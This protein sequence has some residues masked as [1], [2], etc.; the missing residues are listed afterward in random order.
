MTTTFKNIRRSPYQAIAAI[1][2]TGSTVFVVAVFI[3]V[4]AASHLLL[5]NFETKPQIIAYLKDSHTQEQVNALTAKLSSTPYVKQ[6]NYVSKDQALEFY[7]KS[8]ANDPLLLGSITDLGLITADILPASIEVTAKSSSAFNEIT[9]ILKGSELVASTANGQKE[10]DFPQDVVSELSQWTKAIRT[11]GIVLIT[12]LTVNS[13]ITTM[14]IISMKIGNR[15]VEIHTMK[16]LGAKGSFIARPFLFESALYGAFG[17]F[18]GWLAS[19][20]AVLY[21]TPF[22]APR[23]V[24]IIELPVNP[25][26]MLAL[27]AL[28]IIAFSI[29]GF[30]SGLLASVRFVRR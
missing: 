15:R 26:L 2:V 9:E 24:G 28:L 12:I 19:Y 1:F 25:L 14:I 3:L 29:L 11:A 16:L 22:L 30:I 23:L 18:V 17:A 4:S 5:T 6:V 10:I 8:V 13:I 27:L 7:K 20:I 21:S